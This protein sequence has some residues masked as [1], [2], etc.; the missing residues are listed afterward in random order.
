MRMRLNTALMA[1]LV[2]ASA[3]SAPAMADDCLGQP[4][5][6]PPSFALPALPQ[7]EPPRF[8][9]AVPQLPE[10]L[11]AR[12][13]RE[14]G[15]NKAMLDAQ[16]ALAQRERAAME[17]QL[18]QMMAQVQRATE[19]FRPY[20]AAAESADAQPSPRDAYR[21]AVNAAQREQAVE[22]L[23]NMPRPAMPEMPEVATLKSQLASERDAMRKQ[24]DEYRNANRASYLPHREQAHAPAGDPVEAWRARMAEQQQAVVDHQRASWLRHLEAMERCMPAASTAAAPSPKEKG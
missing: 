23:A 22:S 13:L 15:Y 17:E 12:D 8:D 6:A 21:D 14:G 18:Q 9:P 11:S 7:I 3:I 16:L 2:G 4:G 19:S 10:G 5:F 20:Q 1:A 24:M